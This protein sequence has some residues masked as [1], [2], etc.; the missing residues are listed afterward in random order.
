MI[1]FNV[2]PVFLLLICC[3]CWNVLPA[4]KI[5]A[6][7]VLQLMIHK[8]GKHKYALHRFFVCDPPCKVLGNVQKIYVIYILLCVKCNVFILVKQADNFLGDSENMLIIL[9]DLNLLFKK[10]QNYQFILINL[11]IIY[12]MIWNFLFSKIIYLILM[13]DFRLKQT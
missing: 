2:L 13:I 11:N 3:H 1:F 5:T 10:I 6:F 12:I 4:S 7:S 8:D 9:Q